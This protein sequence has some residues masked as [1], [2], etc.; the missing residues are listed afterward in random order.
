MPRPFRLR[1]S[2]CFVRFRIC[3]HNKYVL[4]FPLFPVGLARTP[5][6]L[7]RPRLF[8]GDS[9]TIR[10]YAVPLGGEAWAH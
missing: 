7:V 2:R 6:F 9:P 1:R 5:T 3:S 8:V 4:V 10:A